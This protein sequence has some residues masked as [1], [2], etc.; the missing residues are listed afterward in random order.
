MERCRCIFEDVFRVGELF[1]VC[2]IEVIIVGLGSKD[3]F[4]IC[5]MF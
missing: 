5:K 3:W 4:C 1:E 2:G